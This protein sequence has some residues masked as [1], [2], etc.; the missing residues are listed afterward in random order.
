MKKR[1][2]TDPADWRTMV[3]AGIIIGG[4]YFGY[5]MSFSFV[6]LS[7]FLSSVIFSFSITFSRH[8]FS[9]FSSPLPPSSVN[10]LL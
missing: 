8:S 9:S 5:S 1:S 10:A 3:G 4:V 2:T 7:L 6:F